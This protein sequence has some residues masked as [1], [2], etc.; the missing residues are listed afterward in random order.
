MEIAKH[1][2]T[3]LISRGLVLLS[4]L[5][6]TPVITRIYDPTVY[7]EWV[8]W[9]SLSMVCMPL[10][11]LGYESAIILENRINS[12]SVCKL[13]A[14]I[15]VIITSIIVSIFLYVGIFEKDNKFWCLSFGVFIYTSVLN[16]IFYN[17][18]STFENYK[19]YAALQALTPIMT[20][21][22]HILFGIYT[23][24]S[25]NLVMGTVLGQVFTTIIIIIVINKINAL[26]IKKSIQIKRLYILGKKHFRYP[27]FMTPYNLIGTLRERLIYFFIGGQNAGIGSL[28]SLSYRLL[29]IPNTVVAASIRPLVFQQFQKYGVS[30]F[31]KIVVSLNSIKVNLISPIWA[32]LLFNSEQLCVNFLG[33]KWKGAGEIFIYVSI[34][35]FPHMFSN[36]LDRVFDVK[37]KQKIAFFMELATFILVSAGLAI[38]WMYKSSGIYIVFTQ[39]IIMGL[40]YIFYHIL[41]YKIANFDLKKLI[42]LYLKLFVKIILF[43]LLWSLFSS[44][45]L[46]FIFSLFALILVLIISI[47]LHSNQLKAFYCDLNS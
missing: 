17:W 39:M 28:Y 42:K 16:N 46:S 20:S 8:I 11:T 47:I 7:E 33:D 15:G 1:A 37:G 35:T 18:V 26:K 30:K 25:K 41:I 22:F 44:F 23:D 27:F 21:L 13:C 36:Y 45:N 4:I 29:N 14:M 40:I 10:V 32:W 24:S 43:T 31:E 3:L 38:N 12:S 34:A 6:M 2:I 5:I 19:L 9:F